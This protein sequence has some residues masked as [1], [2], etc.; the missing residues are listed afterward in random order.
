MDCGGGTCAACPVGQGCRLPSDCVSGV[1]AQGACAPGACGDGLKTPDAGETDVDCGGPCARCANGRTCGTGAD[2]V[3]FVCTGTTCSAPTCTDGVANG[4]ETAVDCGGSCTGGTTPRRCGAGL[5][6]LANDDCL[7]LRCVGGT[8]AAAA[9]NDTLLNGTETDVDCGGPACSP[10]PS[11]KACLVNTDCVGMVCP[12]ATHRCTVPAVFAPAMGY[13][14]SNGPGAIAAADLDADGKVDLLVANVTSSE[15]VVHW[16]LGDGTF[17]LTTLKIA[18]PGFNSTNGP[19]TALVADF[20]AD[21]RP[22]I[23]TSLRANG[24]CCT[25]AGYVV[26]Y[27]NLGARAFASGVVVS[28]STGDFR[29]PF[30]GAAAAA[31]LDGDGRADVVSLGLPGNNSDRWMSTGTGFVG[32]QF[33]ERGDAVATGD[34]DGDERAEVFL[35]NHAGSYVATVRMVDG[36]VVLGQQALTG[37]GAGGITSGD[38]TN[39]GRT[40]VCVA[41]P[42]SNTLG[43]LPGLG[44]GN[45][46]ATLS[47]PWR[48]A[49]GLASLDVD[50]DRF[51][52]VVA[53]SGGVQVLRGNGDGTF[54]IN[55]VYETALGNVAAFAVGDFN[56]D[57]KPDVALTA[58]GRVWVLL[59]LLRAVAHRVS[60]PSTPRSAP[61][62]GCG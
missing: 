4:T 6:C 60:R 13:D 40:D 58:N 55:E 17:S 34:F 59:T 61:P 8:C 15:L 22:D 62:P 52:D 41:S 14:S 50:G 1:C 47:F 57:M 44:D 49:S 35:K 3:S 21:G 54:R 38:F 16:G 53:G 12:V 20:D 2:C 29:V 25:H 10:C 26:T 23:G 42:G 36:G 24:G 43:I 18:V 56:G 37:P 28:R 32:S 7:S 27:R 48:A 9:C 19:L 33:G 11:G 30:P 46:Q 51:L 39:D 5:P 45:F 31:D